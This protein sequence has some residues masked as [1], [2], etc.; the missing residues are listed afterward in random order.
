[1]PTYVTENWSSPTGDFAA[2]KLRFPTNATT[3]PDTFISYCQ[4]LNSENSKFPPWKTLQ[5]LLWRQ[6]Y[7]SG[8][9][10]APLYDDILPALRKL[11]SS[12][13]AIYIYSSGSIEAQKLL[14]AHTNHGDITDLIDGCSGYYRRV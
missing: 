11:K 12:G 1:L 5:G 10:K 6:S 9:V 8:S 14:F 2:I 3:S 4:S 13:V 7:E